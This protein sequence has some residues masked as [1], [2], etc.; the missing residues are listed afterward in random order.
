MAVGTTGGYTGGSPRAS[1]YSSLAPHGPCGGKGASIPSGTHAASDRCTV[2]TVS[3]SPTAPA[4]SLCTALPGL[5]TVLLHALSSISASWGRADG[6]IM[7][8]ATPRTVALMT[9]IVTAA[10]KYGINTCCTSLGIEWCTGED[11]EVELRVVQP[12]RV[13]A[14]GVPSRFRRFTDRAT[15]RCRGVTINRR[16]TILAVIMKTVHVRWGRVR[17]L[18]RCRLTF[19]RRSSLLTRPHRSRYFLSPVLLLSGR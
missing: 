17:L 7:L 1:G 3:V 12:R 2:R 19:R 10:R 11:K 4:V 16:L 9:T 14:V 15:R 5:A 8:M 6:P 18:G 13:L